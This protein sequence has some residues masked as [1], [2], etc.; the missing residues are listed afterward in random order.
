ML[1]YYNLVSEKK[2]L[3]MRTEAKLE[4]GEHFHYIIQYANSIQYCLS[5]LV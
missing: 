1:V 5:K 3:C 4:E 2:Y